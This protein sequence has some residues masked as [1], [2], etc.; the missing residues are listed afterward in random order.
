M[1]LRRWLATV[2]L[3]IPGIVFGDEAST[4]ASAPTPI[5]IDLEA[6]ELVAEPATAWPILQV[7]LRNQADVAV[8]GWAF[9]VE[10]AGQPVDGYDDVLVL[11]AAEP[12]ER[13][14]LELFRLEPPPRPFRLRLKVVEAWAAEWLPDE[15]GDPDGEWRL[16]APLDGEPVVLERVVD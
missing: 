8:V 6:V 3:L 2:F 13:V 11:H 1:I 14:I 16:S 15:D 5:A 10:A 7:Q 12:G 4:P 9:E